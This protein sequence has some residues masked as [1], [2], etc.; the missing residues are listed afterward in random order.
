[1]VMA[2]AWLPRRLRGQHL[3]RCM[4][5]L[6]L[7]GWGGLAWETPGPALMLQDDKAATQY[8]CMEHCPLPF[9]T[10]ICG[11]RRPPPPS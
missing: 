9:H 7:T 6:W 10:F 4:I 2:I 1:M 8:D 3:G 5:P 11:L